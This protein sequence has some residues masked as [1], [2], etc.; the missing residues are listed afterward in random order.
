MTSKIVVHPASRAGYA[1]QC[2]RMAAEIEDIAQRQEFLETALS[3]YSAWAA[4]LGVLPHRIAADVA[5]LRCQFFP[6]PERL[7]A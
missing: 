3:K 6:R 5:I 7:R 2:L 1:A 4:G